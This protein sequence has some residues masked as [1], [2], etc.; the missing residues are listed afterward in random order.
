MNKVIFLDIDGVIATSPCWFM[1]KKPELL[2]SYPFDRK[3]V[4]VLNDILMKTGAEI[5]LSS[6][7]KLHHDLKE[8]KII[9]DMN[10]LIKSPI[11]VTP[12]FSNSGKYDPW[13]YS[14]PSLESIRR[15][16]INTYLREH[17]SINRYVIV[18]DLQLEMPNFIRCPYPE[19]G[20]KQTGIK[21][22]IIKM[23]EDK[24]G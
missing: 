2:D 17:S 9:F 10:C 23:L 22:K 1:K 6:D 16:E 7:W 24:N 20:I 4:K 15:S 11:D 8:L 14:T 18:D 19:E 12:D 13:S 5:V 3:A 21:E